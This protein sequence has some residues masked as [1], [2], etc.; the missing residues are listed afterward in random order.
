MLAQKLS[1]ALLLRDGFECTLTR[2][3]REFVSS[4]GL[5]T[6]R[7][8]SQ[9]TQWSSGWSYMTNIGRVLSHDYVNLLSGL[10]DGPT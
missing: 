10:V 4:L 3:H 1:A 7:P 8:L 5:S 6:S 2:A 9:F